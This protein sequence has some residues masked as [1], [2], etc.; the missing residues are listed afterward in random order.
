MRKEIKKAKLT[1]GNTLEVD[2]VEIMD[3]KT[4]RF[5]PGVKCDQLVHPDLTRAF[6]KLKFH[7]AYICEFQESKN[8][9]P[10]TFNPAEDLLKFKVTQ[11]SIGGSDEHEGV[12]LTGQR[13]LEG[14]KI[15]NL[16]SPF[17]QYEDDISGY[18]YSIDLAECIHTCIC[19]VEEYMFNE[20]YAVKQLEI[21]FGET[22][23]E[24]Y[25][26]DVTDNAESPRPKKTRNK[27]MKVEFTNATEAI[28]KL[29]EAAL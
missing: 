4:E 9:S 5:H 26:V 24:G 16:N 25:L 18:P 17:T 8:Y 10:Q 21:P 1:K 23:D 2:L 3:D 19:E 13:E 29:Q 14:D 12:S 7:L 6:D 27:K 15:L 22:E 28:E 11:F 20:K